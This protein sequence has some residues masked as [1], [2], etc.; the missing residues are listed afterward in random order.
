MN[1]F[2]KKSLYILL[3]SVSFILIL[4]LGILIFLLLRPVQ[5][6]DTAPSI[7]S[8]SEE[9]S[10]ADSSDSLDEIVSEKQVP[11]EELSD[12][13]PNVQNDDSLPSETSTSSDSDTSL[14]TSPDESEADMAISESDTSENE[15][16]YPDPLILSDP[17]IY[18]YKDLLSDLEILKNRYS[19]DV[20]IVSLTDTPDGRSVYDMI[21]GDK[22]ASKHILIHAGI[23]AREY[24][25]CQLVMK[26]AVTFLEN[27][28]SDAQYQGLSYRE[29][30]NDTAIHVIPMVNPD[31]ITISQSGCNDI[32]N[33]E[34]LS[35][36]SE[37]ASMDSASL[38][39]SSYLRTWK[40]NAEGI[41]LNRCFDACWEEYE[42]TG[43][44]S[45]DKYKGTRIGD[46]KE[47]QALIDLTNAYPF[48]RTISYH[49]AGSLIY[50]RFQQ[51]YQTE[52]TI[53]VTDSWAKELSSYTGYPVDENY[54]GVDAAGYKDW[55][56]SKLN[57]PSI[58]IE[59]G[60]GSSP[61]DSSQFEKIWSENEQVFE[62][63]LLS[64]F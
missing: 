19:E 25:T 41:D 37:I 16:S 30:L 61:L 18:S 14:Q 24:M 57:I 34:V 13:D 2:S 44:P 6:E 53:A 4:L 22:N 62:I 20:E 36:L 58:T 40:A 60:E 31:G 38:E 39:D 51:F 32:S 17:Q 59:I 15:P 27:L 46:A 33:E 55:A 45:C 43:H 54:N 9:E 26:Q 8:L 3:G 52:D 12:N 11:E 56:L 35:Y 23:H 29:L 64:L 7:S 42:G 47:A 21:I 49:T 63:T 1:H 50:S 48:V 10:F 28:N 5:T